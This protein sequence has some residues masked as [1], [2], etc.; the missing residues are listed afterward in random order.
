[1][2]ILEVQPEAAGSFDDQEEVV[3]TGG[4]VRGWMSSILRLPGEVVLALPL[5]PTWATLHI[6]F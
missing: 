2:L 3:F 1:M 6:G 4:G 5:S